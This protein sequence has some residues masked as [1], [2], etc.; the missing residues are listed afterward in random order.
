VFNGDGSTQSFTLTYAPLGDVSLFYNAA[1]NYNTTAEVSNEAKVIGVSGITTSSFDFT[2][3][4]ATKKISTVGGN[5]GGFTPASATGDLLAIYT[6]IVEIPVQ[7]VDDVSVAE[8]LSHEKTLILKDVITYDDVV[9]RAAEIVEK[10]KNPFVSTALNVQWDSSHSFS[11]GNSIRV[12]DSVNTPTVDDFFTIWGITLRWP[13]GFDEVMVGDREFNP[14]EFFLNMSEMINA[15]EKEVYDE[16]AIFSLLRSASFDIEI[17]P[18]SSTVLEEYIND[19]F[20]LDHS[21]NGV[22]YSTGETAILDDFESSAGFSAGSGS[23]SLTITNNS[24]A[25]QFWVGSQGVKAAWAVGSG[26]GVLEK[27]IASVDLQNVVGVTSGT[28]LQGTFGV[29]VFTATPSCLTDLKLRIGSSSTDYKEYSGQQYAWKVA[30]VASSF[31][32]DSSLLTLVLFDADTVSATSGSID[33]TAVDFMQLRWTIASAGNL[34]FDYLTGSKNNTISLNG[35]G[36]R[37]TQ[38]SSTT[39]LY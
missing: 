37:M 10:F 36:S 21:V 9:S 18:Y 4:K 34:T 38:K 35:L 8:N 28:P 25:S 17:L 33:W 13:D 16:N 32:V 14:P 6:A 23:V 29:W 11:L 39:T 22:L 19:S 24:T 7:K 3:D 15:L 20:I 2:V 30:G 1:K 31:A 26:T 12:V 27:A 5:G